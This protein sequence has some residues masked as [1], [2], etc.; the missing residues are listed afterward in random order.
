MSLDTVKF[1]LP[2]GTTF[3]LPFFIDEYEVYRFVPNQVV[4]VGFDEKIFDLNK[5]VVMCANRNVP[6][7]DRIIF[8]SMLGYSVSGLCDLSMMYP[9]R[10]VTP[11]WVK[12]PE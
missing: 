11:T 7:K 3:E 5:I 12:E 10:V 6:L 9:V 8:W 1:E 4:S 2:D